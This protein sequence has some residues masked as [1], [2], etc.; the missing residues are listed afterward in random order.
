M[1]C[2]NPA[3]HVR[4]F[5]KCLEILPAPYTS[6]DTNRLTVAYFCVAGLDVL[7]ALHK[8]DREQMIRW[9]YAQQACDLA[10][11]RRNPDLILRALLH[12]GATDGHWRCWR[13]SWRSLPGW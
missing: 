9:I 13:L 2:V 1:A 7:G 8:V 10:C 12:L 3:L 5:L 11:A 6:L 4:Y